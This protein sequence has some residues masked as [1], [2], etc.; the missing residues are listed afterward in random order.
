MLA[1]ASHREMPSEVPIRHLVA[2]V[3]VFVTKF[4]PLRIAAL[5]IAM[6]LI[7][8]SCSSDDPVPFRGNAAGA[9]DA[10]TPVVYDEAVVAA[11]GTITPLIELTEFAIEGDLVVPAGHVVLDVQNK[12]ALEH[13]LRLEGG[14]ITADLTNGE[15]D[16][17]DLGELAPGTYVFIC[18]IAGHQASGME[19]TLT[20]VDPDDAEAITLTAS[21]GGH[22]D[23]P[24]W[25]EL[26][27]AMQESMLAFPASTEGSGNKPL[28]F[29][30]AEDGAKVF[31]LTVAI[32]PWEVAPG[33]FVD[34]WTYNEQVPGPAIA[35]E[36]GDLVRVNV[37]NDLPMGTDIHWH[38]IQT[39]NNMDGVAPLTQPLILSGESFV[40]EFVAQRSS[41]GMYHAHHHAQMQIPNGLFGTFVIGE[42]DIP[43]GETIGG[44]LIPEDLVISQR[45]PMVLNDAGVIGYSLN[46][47]SFPATEPTVVST[48][49]W[50]VVEYYNEGLQIHPMHMHQFPQLVYAKDGFPLDSPYY[51]DT[52]NVAPGERYSVLVQ[53]DLAGAWVWHCHILTHVEDDEGMFGMVTAV[54]VQDT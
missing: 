2:C 39:P 46:G 5:S 48:D 31:D 8:A 50:I 23:D 3:E 10:T 15:S 36:V 54:I 20:V 21:S 45:I 35:V 32:T 24:D 34:A 47:K 12:G 22:G 7:A 25:E 27:R 13:N 11:D 16:S 41:V 43:R 44:N 26:D 42:P 1:E 29:T 38:G 37:Q 19:T 53:P 17:L 6:V 33:E 18:E 4:R 28:E 14:P 49:E 52:I 30:I 9:G 51:A 40:Y